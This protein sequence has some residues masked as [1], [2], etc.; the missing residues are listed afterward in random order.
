MYNGS[1]FM[2]ILLMRYIVKERRP[3]ELGE[4]I[5]RVTLR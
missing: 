3:T 2:C 4:C 5:D 1:H